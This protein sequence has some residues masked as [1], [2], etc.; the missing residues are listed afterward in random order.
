M[1]SR[2]CRMRVGAKSVAGWILPLAVLAAGLALIVTDFGHYPA[3]IRGFEFDTYQ[4]AKPRPYE[5]TADRSGF[6]VRVLD[7]DDASIAR[8]GRWPWPH[9]TLGK[10]SD[11]LKTAGAAAI[12]FAFPLDQPEAAAAPP[13][14]PESAAA[15]PPPPSPADPLAKS[16]AEIKAV[17]GFTLGEAATRA[18]ALRSGIEFSGDSPLRAIP[19][20]R[21]ALPALPDIEKASAGVG[22]L[23]I[24]ADAD[25]RLRSVPMV[26]RLGDTAV[27]SIEAEA[28]RI[29]S[30][31][32]NIVV[33]SEET[34]LPG[35]GG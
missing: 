20:Y 12:V 32:P 9:A 22:A 21:D 19:R 33:R 17:T 29:A 7:A 11:E 13:P 8:F 18:P 1:K 27:P 23:N 25:G 34:G 2:W 14:Q 3:R 31:A 16:I 4:H 15:N 28:I 6:R 24:P 5:D 10:L 35:V 30:G 26:L